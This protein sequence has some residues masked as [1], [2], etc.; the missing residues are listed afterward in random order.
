[1]SGVLLKLLLLDAAGT[2]V[3]LAL[4]LVVFYF[5]G[6]H[7]WGYLA[8]ILV[9]LGASVMATKY[10]SEKK[11]NMAL[12]EYNRG[13]ENVLANGIV[14]VFCVIMLPGVGALGAYVG[15]LAA[16]TS[17]KFS[18]EIGVLG[19]A[20]RR[21][22]D[23]KPVKRGQSG[24]VSMLG[25]FASFDGALLVGI[26]AYLLFSGRYDAWGV[27]LITGIGVFGSVVD[28]AVGVLENSGVGN[29]MTTNVVCAVAGALLGYLLL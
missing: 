13:W 29:K 10:G 19:G 9:F 27:L 25:F 23:L 20:P 3:A 14:P 8:L 15:S 28:S 24:A 6:E 7:G 22:F 26:A 21:L 12:Y 1:L 18:S 5:G 4:G 11:K 16:V 17:D 2:L